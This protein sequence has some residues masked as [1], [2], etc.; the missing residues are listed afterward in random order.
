MC[1]EPCHWIEL[2]DYIAS[3]FG[4]VTSMERA[5]SGHFTRGIVVPRARLDVMA[6]K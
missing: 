1:S 5:P 4:C 6:M 2:T 3:S